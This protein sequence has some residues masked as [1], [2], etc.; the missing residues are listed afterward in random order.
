MRSGWRVLLTFS[1]A[2]ATVG[3]TGS[4]AF[5]YNGDDRFNWSAYAGSIEQR[6]ETKSTQQGNGFVVVYNN[7]TRNPLYVIEKLSKASVSD[8][9]EKSKRPPFH[10]EQAVMEAFRITSKDYTDSKYDRGHMVPAADFQEQSDCFSGTFTMANISPQAPLLNKGFWARFEAW[11]RSYL[12]KHVF[13]EVYVITGP[14]FAP[15]FVNNQWVYMQRTVGVFPRLVAVPSHFFKVVVGRK[16][17]SKERVVAAFLVPNIDGVPKESRLVWS[18]CRP[19][20]YPD[21][22]FT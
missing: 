14:V 16:A 6:L 3:I 18:K 2:T 11:I 19:N 22:L 13:E 15:T 12:L 1:S 10:P 4:P 7:Q 20:S 8:E 21:L 17:N 5:N 9:I